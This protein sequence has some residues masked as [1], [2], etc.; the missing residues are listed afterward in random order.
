MTPY[1]AL[2]WPGQISHLLKVALS[3]T[4]YKYCGGGKNPSS[5]EV[6]GTEGLLK[7]DLQKG[8]VKFDCHMFTKVRDTKFD[9]GN[10]TKLSVNS[11][12][13]NSL[14]KY[15]KVYILHCVFI[16]P[17]L[18]YS[19]KSTN[20]QVSELKWKLYLYRKCLLIFTHLH[21]VQ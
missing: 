9:F 20:S 6:R 12:Q 18:G 10:F 16:C 17:L 2:R 11:H 7:C 4:A 13:E 5:E 21:N 19:L 15:F 1:Y 8:N 14:V 3:S